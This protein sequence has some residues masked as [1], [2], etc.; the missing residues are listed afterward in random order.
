MFFLFLM[1]LIPFGAICYYGSSTKIRYREY[2]LTVAIGVIPSIVT[3][4]LMGAAAKA[5]IRNDIP[6]PL[7]VLIIALLA[8][9]RKQEIKD[10]LPMMIRTTKKFE[11]DYD[12]VLAGAPSIDEAYY[13]QFLEG[14]QVRLIKNQT[15]ALL[16]EAH[17]ALV[18][19]GTA[20]LETALFNV[21][22]VVC[23][24]TPLPRLIGWLR[25]K[26]LK[27]KYISLVNLVANREVVRELV[28]DSFTFDNIQHELEI[29]LDGPAREKMLEGYQEVWSKLG[30]EHAPANAAKTMLRLLNG[31]A[32]AISQ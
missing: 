32:P 24:E 27:V 31:D 5:F 30:K 18:T 1:P 12:I 2:I 9:S 21:P 7:L 29:I 8:G 11:N 3:S 19:S 17:A 15:Y 4:N 13:Q 25:K 22:Q 6:I 23:Y 20:T 28:A 14:S 16:S 10:N 26:I